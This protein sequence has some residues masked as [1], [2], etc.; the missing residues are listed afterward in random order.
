[1]KRSDIAIGIVVFL[2][3]TLLGVAV[4][5]YLALKKSG[6]QVTVLTEKNEE[7]EEKVER[8]S[9]DVSSGKEQQDA[10]PAGEK[11]GEDPDTAPETDPGDADDDI[12]DTETPDEDED[13]EDDDDDEDSGREE[14]DGFGIDFTTIGPIRDDGRFKDYA[15]EGNPYDETQYRYESMI[16]YPTDIVFLGDSLIAKGAWE[17]FY[18]EYIVKNRGISG[19]TIDGI[20]ARMDSIVAT[21]PDR[22]FLMVGINDI[23]YGKL[24]TGRMEHD[25]KLLLDE[26]RATDA[27]IYVMSILPV[28]NYMQE[29]VG[30]DIN[31]WIGEANDMIRGLCEDY[32]AHYIDVRG[33]MKDGSGGLRE[34]LTIDGVHLTGEGYRIWK[35][36]LDDY[37]D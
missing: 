1:M 14:P 16:S 4:I 5:E 7:L 32:D 31:S 22:I 25:Y 19:D 3:V 8:L 15:I 2:C 37:I 33:G 28:A 9:A 27:E 29:S 36:N 23:L 6:E 18:P 26:I 34:E 10:E 11:P 13:D 35:E 24:A 21:Q 17:E 30:G 12:E 20:R